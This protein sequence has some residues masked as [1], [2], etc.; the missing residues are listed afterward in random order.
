MYPYTSHL[1][2]LTH[3]Y[4]NRCTPL[5]TALTK[6]NSLTT[7]MY[8]YMYIH[9]H[10]TE[11]SHVETN[12]FPESSLRQPYTSPNP[13]R[14]MILWILKSCREICVSKHTITTKNVRYKCHRNM[15]MC[16]IHAHGIQEKEVKLSVVA[17][18][19]TS[20]GM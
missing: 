7:Y 11:Q 6:T 8:M 14:P 19:I 16:I 20:T 13:P 2:T 3:N 9:V 12:I 1:H 15:I 17:S 5:H 18:T 10:P 4:T